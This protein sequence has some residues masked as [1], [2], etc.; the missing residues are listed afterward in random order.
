MNVMMREIKYFAT[1]RFKFDDSNL[2]ALMLSQSNEDKKL[3]NMDLSKIQWD[4]YFLAC[5][6]GIKKNV[7]KDSDDIKPA[8]ERY[9]K[10]NKAYDYNDKH[11]SYMFKFYFSEL[12]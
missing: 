7:L 9:K 8:Q 2:Q 3:F 10:Y 12:W 1:T 6:K 5:I 4:D 11:Y